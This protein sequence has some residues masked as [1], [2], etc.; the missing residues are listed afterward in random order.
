[1]TAIKPLYKKI[2][3]AKIDL[4]LK[5]VIATTSRSGLPRSKTKTIK[6]PVNK[7]IANSAD[8]LPRGL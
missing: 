5:V 4:K 2:F 6:P 8:N 7:Q 3:Q 1:M